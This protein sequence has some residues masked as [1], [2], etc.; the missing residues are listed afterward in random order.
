[1][2]DVGDKPL[3]ARKATARGRILLSPDTIALIRENG[4]KKGDLISVAQIAGIMAAK[5]LRTDSLCHQLNLNRADV[6][7]TVQDDG[8]TAEG[9]PP[10]TAIPE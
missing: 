4:L 2:V 7:I 3:S 1:M 6:I 9:L 8:V 5:D 10:A